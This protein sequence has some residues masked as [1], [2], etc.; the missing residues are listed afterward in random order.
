MYLL[1]SLLKL[2]ALVA[3]NGSYILRPCGHDLHGP[4]IWILKS[5]VL[6]IADTEKEIWQPI[7]RQPHKKVAEDKG[8]WFMIWINWNSENLSEIKF[9]I[10]IIIM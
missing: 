2:N 5:N 6:N 8:R 7:F 3:V 4:T 9:K 1:L 10:W